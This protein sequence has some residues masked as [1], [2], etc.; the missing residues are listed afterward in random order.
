MTSKVQATT[1]PPSCPEIGTALGD[2]LRLNELRAPRYTSYP[3]ALEFSA[4]FTAQDYLKAVNRTN[5]EP[6]P[7]PLSLYLHLP[8]CASSCYYCGCN[9]VISRNHQRHQN[10]LHLLLREIAMQARLFAGDRQVR[11]IHFGGG[12]PNL[13]RP[14]ELARVLR[15]LGQAFSI[16]DDCETSMEVDPRQVRDR[17]ARA[18]AALGF[19]RISI[20]VQDVDPKVQKAVNR[21]QPAQGVARLVAEARASGIEGINFDLIYGL[22]KQTLSSF[23]ATLDF[24][25]A[26]RPD[27]I[28]VFHYAHLPSRFPAQQAI[29]D[30]S[31]PDAAERLALQDRI[32]QRLTSAGYIHIGLDH[33]A[34]AEDS[35]AQ[36]LGN[37]T[38]QRNF[39]G[40]ST[41]AECDLI[42][43]GVSAISHI[44]NVYAQNHSDLKQYSDHLE[45]AQ[46][47][48]Y[49]GLQVGPEDLCRDAVIRDIMC[50]RR[51]DFAEIEQRFDINF[52]QTF[53]SALQRLR[54]LDPKHRLV[55]CNAQ[56]LIVE[57]AG[58]HVL[59]LIAQCFD[60]YAETRGQQFMAKAL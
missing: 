38:L 1:T 52:G 28:A 7:A 12:T 48:T 5:E 16:A 9:R 58:R 17:D 34:L 21:L 8:F 30:S 31:L 50:R 35:L 60:A 20:G 44:D 27:R 54:E 6:L 33:F 32:T 56:T 37:G 51:V 55:R 19:N 2:H 14:I 41:S 59:R 3:T 10:Y 25:E 18:W 36:A 11:Q 42:G 29:D 45:Q 47:A 4:Q 26:Q 22:P 39:Q 40:Y 53:A 23:D 49:R 15:S 13:Y 24:V 57:P 46:L 43:F